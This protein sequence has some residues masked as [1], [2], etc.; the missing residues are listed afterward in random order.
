MFL[1]ES[2][3]LWKNYFG[4]GQ[5]FELQRAGFLDSIKWYNDREKKKNSVWMTKESRIYWNFWK[6]RKIQFEW[7]KN[8]GFIEIEILKILEG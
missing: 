6:I 3:D 1:L 5:R 8:W 2:S 4:V 7:F